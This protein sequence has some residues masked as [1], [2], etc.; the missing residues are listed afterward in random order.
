MHSFENASTSISDGKLPKVSIVTISYNQ[1]DFL[2]DALR[3][4]IGQDYPQ[5][6]Y[7]VLDP[8]STDGSREII[9]Q[10]RPRIST[11][12]FEPD[13]GPADG[14]N[15]GFLHA[16]GEVFGF[17]N[18]DDILYP[19]AVSAAAKV[20]AER[21]DV[22]VVSGHAK[23][24]GPDGRVLRLAFSDRMSVAGYLYGAVAMIQPSTFF[25]REAYLRA[26]GFNTG[27]RASW[28]G[29]LFLT[30]AANGARFATSDN[31]WSGYRLHNQ[32]ITSSRKLDSVASQVHEGLFLRMMG[33]RPNRLD[34]L[35]SRALKTWKH[36][37]NPRDTCER[38]LRGPIYGRR[39]E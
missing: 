17:L 30:M 29:E 36:V 22:D 18:S 25:R 37:I 5:I 19:G 10:Y 31:I 6:E 21:P 9:E 39:V 27:N 13:R 34:M 33:R 16:T 32:S 15:K 12:I 11:V 38:L 2:T 1:A 7:I 4:V 23:V 20:L 24:I 35:I 14:L 3:S 28:D 26:G 8:G